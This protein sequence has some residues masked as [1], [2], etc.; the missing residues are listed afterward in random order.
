MNYKRIAITADRNL[1]SNTNNARFKV[2]GIVS[3]V[4]EVR[5]SSA[6]ILNKFRNVFPYEDQFYILMNGMNGIK[7]VVKFKEATYLSPSE[8]VEEI[9]TTIDRY[10]Q[11]ISFS[12]DERR[13]KF[14]FEF[15]PGTSRAPQIFIK[16]GEFSRLTGFAQG[17]YPPFPT[18]RP[19]TITSQSRANI[20]VKNLKIMLPKYTGDTPIGI[21]PVYGKFGREI[22]LTKKNVMMEEMF[23]WNKFYSQCPYPSFSFL[24]IRDADTNS[25]VDFVDCEVEINLEFRQN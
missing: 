21:I 11:G 2:E 8:I 24:E 10:C 9:Q 22:I 16:E 17:T 15:D 3:P 6:Y 1:Y 13:M 19:Y 12:F 4:N 7:R 18:D 20:Y 5:I 25:L 23:E 14:T